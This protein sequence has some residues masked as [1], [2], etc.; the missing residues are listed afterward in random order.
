MSHFA[1]VNAYGI[2]EQVIVAEQDFIDSLTDASSWVKTSYN[3]LGG[4]HVLGGEPFRKNFACVGGV[5]DPIRDAFIPI[6]PFDSWVLDE[7]SCLWVA[8]VPLPD[9]E[10][11]YQWDEVS[12]NWIAISG[13]N[14]DLD[15]TW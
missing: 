3:T 9:T 8:P 10:N 14:E 7:A 12:K 2:V 4:V 11:M 5:Y 1:R 13:I 15:A 6:K